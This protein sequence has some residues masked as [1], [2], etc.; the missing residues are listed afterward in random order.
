MA[1]IKK[2]VVFLVACCLLFISSCVQAASLSFSPSAGSYTVGNTFSVNVYVSSA[3]QAMNAASGAVSFPA[4]KLE[5]VSLSKVGSVFSLW[6]QEPSFSNTSGVANFEGVVLNPGFLGASGK[7]V[8]LNFKAKSSGSATISFASGSILANDG[9]GTNILTAMK[10]A[11]FNIQ[12]A[13]PQAS[14]P[15]SAPALGVPQAPVI[16]SPTHPNQEKWYSNNKPKFAWQLPS[17]ATAVRMLFDKYPSSPPVVL[18]SQPVFEKQLDEVVDGV[19]YFHC[20]FK[21]E[22][23]WGKV[24]HFRFQIDTQPPE[25]FSIVSEEGEKTENPQP[26]ILFDTVDKLSGIDFFK[27]KIND[28]NLTIPAENKLKNNPYSLPLQS[29]GKK[30]I[31]VQAF[32]KAGNFFSTSTE[33]EIVAPNQPV[34]A[35]QINE[36][37][38]KREEAPKEYLNLSQVVIGVAFASWFALLILIVIYGLRK[39]RRFKKAIHRGFSKNEGLLLKQRAKFQKNLQKNLGIIFETQ[40]KRPLTKTEQAI[41]K[42]LEKE[43]QI[44]QESMEKE[45]RS[46]SKIQK[47]D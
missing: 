3:D 23:G 20:Q 39:I 9:Q 27:L 24:G 47:I 41:K 13:Q 45:L 37:A 1:K 10:S 12:P 2:Q 40:T 22:S 18:Y 16:F 46:K 36:K 15:K 14:E 17:N 43:N 7:I 30:T 4:D 33:L 21:N 28:G 8:T 19:W 38:V 25:A 5:V 42:S 35:E 26:A 29:P 6:V 11:L 31:I 32:D 44:I 34:I